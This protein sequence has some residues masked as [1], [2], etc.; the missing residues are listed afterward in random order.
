MKPVKDHIDY[1]VKYKA[2]LKKHEQVIDRS[3]KFTKIQ[4]SLIT[5]NNTIDKKL[6]VY[7]RINHYIKKTVESKHLKEFKSYIPEALID[8][9]GVEGALVVFHNPNRKASYC[10]GLC[11]DTDSDDIYAHLSKLLLHHSAREPIY[12]DPEQ[13]STYESLDDF[14]S[15]LCRK[16]E[17]ASENYKFYLFGFISKKHGA[18]YQK[19]DDEELLV[20]DNFAEQM[21]TILRH[22]LIRQNLEVEKEKY[23][24]IIANMNL[25]LLEVNTKEEILLANQTFCDMAGYDEKEILG[26]VASDL[27]LEGAEKKKMLAQNQT[28][29]YKKASVYEVELKHKNGDALTW[30]ISGAPN[31]DLEGNVVGSIGIHLD[32]TEQKLIEQN[33]YNTNRDLKK[34]NS[35]LDTLIYRVS[36]DLRTPLLSIISL[37]DLIK[38]NTDVDIGAQNKE[39]IGLIQGSAIRL[40]NSIKEILNYSRNSRLDLEPSAINLPVMVQTICDDLRYVN[41]AIAFNFNFNGIGIITVDKMRLETVLKNLLSNA[42][43]Y[44]KKTASDP[45]LHFTISENQSEYCIVISDNGIGMSET[46]VKKMFDMFY[47][48]TSDSKGTGLGLFIVKEMIDK[49]NGNIEVE[50]QID[51]GTTFTLTLPKHS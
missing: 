20:F 17:S 24:S 7:K 46:G 35:E 1:E 16:F 50:S 13:L 8:C 28:R 34:T 36:H 18:N 47:R 45:E 3:Q 41:S 49:L 19:L 25:G 32:V 48:G 29:L 23:R 21:H 5:A 26:K 51:V 43:K 42:V 2:L 40:D 37:I 22:R 33:L 27:F 39:F 14:E 10:E 38:L 15:V 4:Q 9:F 6:E 31:Y 30:M 12:L 44:Q 11:G